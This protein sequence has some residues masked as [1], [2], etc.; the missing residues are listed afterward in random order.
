MAK[1]PPS[2]RTIEDVGEFGLIQVIRAIAPSSPHGLVLGIGDDTAAFRP[3][4]GMLTLATCDIQ[5]EGRHFLRDRT[6]A[7][8]LGRRAAAIN[9]SDIAA[10][11]GEPRYAL[12]SLALDQA[13]EVSWVEDLYRGLKDEM[14]QVGAGVIGGNL[15]AIAGPT[16]IDITLIGEVAEHE[17]VRRSG[18][19]AG[20]VVL[21]TGS[22]GS[23][24]AGLLA[25]ERGLDIARPDVAQA[26][27][28]HLTPTPRVRE[29]RTIGRSGKATAMIDVSDGLAGDLGHICEASGLGA[30]LIANNLPLAQETRTLATELGKD[31]VALALH[32]GEDF[33]LCFTCRAEDA[34][35][36]IATIKQ[37]TGTDVRVVGTMMASPGLILTLPDGREGPLTKG[38]WDHFASR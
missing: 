23:S 17:M 9:L 29:G 12:V 8:Q 19:H 14:A 36:L 24:A 13:I 4:P 10:M 15:S 35:T 38:G 25:L 3:T 32:G 7:Y 30:R 2:R 11:G 21:V 34:G 31:A 16:V 28:A 1:S 22:L 37:N 27:S 6:T 33:E 5:V 20:D 18:A 26:V